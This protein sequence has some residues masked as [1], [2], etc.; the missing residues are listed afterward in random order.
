MRRVSQINGLH[1]QKE[2]EKRE[3]ATLAK[4]ADVYGHLRILHEICSTDA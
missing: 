4:D 3:I 2:D 1:V